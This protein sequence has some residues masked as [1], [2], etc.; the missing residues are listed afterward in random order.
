[1]LAS[2]HTNRGSPLRSSVAVPVS[3]AAFSM[4]TSV[5]SNCSPSG[6]DAATS[7]VA[8]TAG[9]TASRRNVG[10]PSSSVSTTRCGR[11]RRHDD[12]A[13][14]GRRQ[15]DDAFVDLGLH[16][17]L[18][19]RL[20]STANQPSAAA[21]SSADHA[22]DLRDRRAR[23][24]RRLDQGQRSDDRRQTLP[25]RFHLEVERAGVSAERPR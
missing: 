3:L 19:R 15:L 5:R 13:A 14:V 6:I 18:D 21:P 9:V 20:R 11:G 16:G 25:L 10:S 17:V 24:R 12:D 2:D 1:M 8:P 22:E 7:A 4:R 23:D